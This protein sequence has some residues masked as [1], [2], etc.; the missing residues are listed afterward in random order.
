MSL[1][2]TTEMF[3]DSTL[4]FDF[5]VDKREIKVSEDGNS[6]I[7]IEQMITPFISKKV[8]I[9]TIFHLI[10]SNNTWQINFF[11]V[12]LIPLNNDLSIID[13]ALE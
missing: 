3:S 1:K 7:V 6:A 4:K 2:L 5:T 9:R 11:S 12:A 8:P 10:R 13:K